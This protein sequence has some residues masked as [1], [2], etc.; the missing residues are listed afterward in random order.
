[1]LEPRRRS[2]LKATKC[3][4][5]GRLR[6]LELG[7][8]LDAGHGVGLRPFL[9]LNDIEFDIVSFFQAFVSIQLDRAVV[10]EDVR[11]VIAADETVTLRIVEPLHF[12]FVL[13][14][15]PVDLP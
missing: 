5:V 14:H 10:N 6:T 11:S 2:Q 9:T 8:F 4:S 1:M 13:C 15:L 12:A 3:A 7:Y